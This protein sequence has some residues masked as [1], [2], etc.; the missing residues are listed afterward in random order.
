[1]IA[2]KK[3]ECDHCTLPVQIEGIEVLTKEGLKK[4]CCEGCKSLYAMLHNDLILTSATE[5]KKSD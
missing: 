4:F 2:D 5:Q 3:T 1:M